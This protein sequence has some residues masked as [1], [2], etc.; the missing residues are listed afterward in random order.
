MAL[1]PEILHLYLSPAVCW[2]VCSC[3]AAKVKTDPSLSGTQAHKVVVCSDFKDLS[4][5][6][7]C[8]FHFTVYDIKDYDSYPLQDFNIQ[9]TYLAIYYTNNTCTIKQNKNTS[10]LFVSNLFSVKDDTA[11][12]SDMILR[13]ESIAPLWYQRHMLQ[14]TT[15]TQ[16]LQL[17]TNICLLTH[18]C[19]AHYAMFF[20]S[21]AY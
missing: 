11:G 6:E 17:N 14:H 20:I 21:L 2:S 5:L 18:S 19:L 7:F 9:M 4:K 12:P 16:Y 13:L 15:S 3:L 8:H 1:S 10:V